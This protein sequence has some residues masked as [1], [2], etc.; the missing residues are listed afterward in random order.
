[1]A[2]AGAAALLATFKQQCLLL[3]LAVLCLALLQTD[4]VDVRP[5]PFCSTPEQPPPALYNTRGQ[6]VPQPLARRAKL[7]AQLPVNAT[8]QREGATYSWLYTQIFNLLGWAPCPLST[9]PKPYPEPV[10]WKL[11]AVLNITSMYGKEF[12]QVPTAAVLR[13]NTTN[14][15]R[16]LLVLIRGSAF[17]ENRINYDYSQIA[18][19]AYGDGLIHRGYY[20]ASE[21]LWGDETAGLQAVLKKLIVDATSGRVTSVL[22]AGHSMGGGLGTLLAARTEK[23]LAKECNSTTNPGA[24]K[25]LPASLRAKPL[26]SLVGFAACN[27]GSP[28]F[29]AD[30][31]KR[32]NARLVDFEFDR[33]RKF[34]TAYN[35]TSDWPAPATPVNYTRVGGIVLLPA[36][37]MPFQSSVWSTIGSTVPNL[38]PTAPQGAQAFTDW[39]N[40]KQYKIAYFGLTYARGTLYSAGAHICSYRCMLSQFVANAKGD[41]CLLHTGDAAELAKA[42]YCGN[43]PPYGIASVF[44]TTPAYP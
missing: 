38:D 29:A 12:T 20:K 11:E 22:F 7:P 21:Q 37:G 9:T 40:A 4:A 27:A 19:P 5:D 16:Q 42:T 17:D 44:P 14:V 35:T 43:F 36:N 10:G 3:L 6:L 41:W 15:S 24:C 39:D 1:M 34:L 25:F 28:A 33:V 2:I 8:L 32:V 26:V 13:P 30:F 18:A 31:N 23:Y